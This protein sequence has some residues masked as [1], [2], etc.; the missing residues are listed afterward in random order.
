M[1]GRG[2]TRGAGKVATGVK[3]AHLQY[4]HGEGVPLTIGQIGR[5]SENEFGRAIGGIEERAMG[6]P[7]L[8]ATIGGARKR[9]DQAFNE[10][11]FRQMGG[12]GATGAAGIAEGQGLVN[13]AYNFLDNTRLPIDPEFTAG[14][15]A[16]RAQLPTLPAFGNEIGKSLDS[17]EAST[18]SGMLS[19]RD[20]QSG[21]RSVRGDR[22]SLAGQPFSDRAVNALG[23]VEDNLMGLAERQGGPDIKVNLGKANA[24]NA[25][26]QTLTGA[27]D[28]GTAQMDEL[29]SA[30]RLDD[31]SRLN[32]RKF[33]GRVNSIVGNR[34]FYELTT[35][36]KRVMPNLTPDS[37][38]AGRML[39]PY[40]LAGAGGAGV[41]A[42][43]GEDNRAQGSLNGLGYG[44]L[45]A[46]AL[47]MPYSKTGQKALQNLLL[48][49]RPDRIEKIGEYLIN[50]SRLGGMFGSAL[51]RD[52]VYQ[53]EL[54][55]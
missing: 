6:L 22:A 44:A 13:N 32:A 43:T 27:L 35:A 1:F 14:N 9:G 15:Q 52:Y 29:F 38:T 34:P 53:P 4:L 39:L 3:N 51:G 54:G 21:I 18:G 11:A 31:F 49:K 19:G 37:G 17:L 47:S 48:G 41:G 26:F 24:L 10:A 45:A 5:G 40:A 16:V 42:V 55:Q 12:S 36:G 25:K 28:N 23:G 20:W 30:K 8:D 46:A 7:G 50:R 2:L 33:G